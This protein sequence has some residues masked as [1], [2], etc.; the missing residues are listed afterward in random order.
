MS[1]SAQVHDFIRQLQPGTVFLLSDI[2]TYEDA[3]KATGRALQ[4][5]MTHE[6]HPAGGVSKIADGL[7][8][9]DK[10]GLLGK[11][12]PSYEEILHA[13]TYQ[14]DTQVGYVVGH[15]LFYQ[16]GLST[17]VP[18]TVSV[19]TSKQAPAN[20]NFAGMRIEVKGKKQS[21]EQQDIK[22]LQLAYV[23]NN[24]D[25]IQSLEGESIYSA[26]LT[27]FD[28]L[29]HGNEQFEKLYERLV[30]KRTKALFGALL[31]HY[32]EQVHRD[33]SEQ[34]DLIENDLSD[35]SYYHLGYIS[36][37]LDNRKRWHI[38]Q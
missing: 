25:K 12:P 35:R 24:I 6:D 37:F 23:L 34:I 19:V 32:Q 1:I 30:Y 17:Q 10:V 31:E 7:Y 21:I 38:R 22:L 28:E 2:A 15:Q 9:K 26:L 18:A 27:Y 33:F 3:R 16:L 14:E 29:N 36:T 4:Y 5:Y 13:L 11:L 8:Y 20:I